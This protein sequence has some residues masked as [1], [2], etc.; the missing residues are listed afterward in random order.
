MKVELGVLAWFTYL[1]DSLTS[2]MSW[3][4]LVCWCL[5]L[6]H[7]FMNILFSISFHYF[8]HW[9]ELLG[10]LVLT[11]ASSSTEKSRPADLKFCVLFLLLLSN[12][13][14]FIA[15]LPFYFSG[16]S[17]IFL[18]WLILF[19]C[20]LDPIPSSLLI[21]MSPVSSLF[22]YSLCVNNYVLHITYTFFFTL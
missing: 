16:W 18:P 13:Y 3:K 5:P 8:V 20:A 4:L 7:A 14:L 19:L 15:I 21:F 17:V 12:Y 9:L 6:L 1:T 11:L 10:S 2:K 22:F